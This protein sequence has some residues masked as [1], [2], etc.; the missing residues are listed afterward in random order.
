MKKVALIVLLLLL[1]GVIRQQYLQPQRLPPEKVV[2]V[3]DPSFPATN[4]GPTEN[5]LQ[6]TPALAELDI[7][8]A[9]QLRIPN[10]I[11]ATVEAS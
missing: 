7:Q 4:S 2:T 8:Q 10:Q 9:A 1:G 3:S 6:P 5:E 11:I